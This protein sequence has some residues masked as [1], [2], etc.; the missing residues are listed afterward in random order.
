MSFTQLQHL[1]S[2][3]CKYFC[4]GRICIGNE[5]KKTAYQLPIKTFIGPRKKLRQTKFQ[6]RSSKKFER[7][8]D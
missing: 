3:D 5:D 7:A 1:K 6:L 8:Q 4:S 2:N